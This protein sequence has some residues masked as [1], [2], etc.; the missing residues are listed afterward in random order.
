MRFEVFTV[1]N[2]QSMTLQDHKNLLTC[3]KQ[4]NAATAMTSVLLSTMFVK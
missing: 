3:V 1:V 4:S 2:I